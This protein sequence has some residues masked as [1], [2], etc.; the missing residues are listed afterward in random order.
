MTPPSDS[1]HQSVIQKREKQSFATSSNEFRIRSEAPRCSGSTA[2]LV[3]ESLQSHKRSSRFVERMGSWQLKFLFLKD[4]T[5]TEYG[6]TSGCNDCFTA[7]P[8]DLRCE[9]GSKPCGAGESIDLGP[10]ADLPQVDDLPICSR[11]ITSDRSFPK[12]AGNERELW[13]RRSSTPLFP[14]HISCQHPKTVGRK[15]K[16][17]EIPCSVKLGGPKSRYLFW[18][19]VY[20]K[21]HIEIE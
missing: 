20:T 10:F 1:R 2:Q 5:W 21:I 6:Q 3:R 13:T 19:L 12:F 14:P 17:E 4:H 18:I 9:G 8:L 16:F 15:Y 7:C 11:S